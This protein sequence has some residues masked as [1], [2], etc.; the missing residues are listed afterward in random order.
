MRTHTF[1]VR[2][3]SSNGES[4]DSRVVVEADAEEALDPEVV[5]SGTP[6]VMSAPI[7]AALLQSLFVS[8][9]RDITVKFQNGEDPDDEI[10]IPAGG[11]LFWY[12]DSGFACPLTHNAVTVSFVN[13]SGEDAFPQLRLLRDST[14]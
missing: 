1:L 7:D 11:S 13:D 9:D 2:Y 14:D 12:R 4:I 10:D 3:G 6:L 8:S 5:E